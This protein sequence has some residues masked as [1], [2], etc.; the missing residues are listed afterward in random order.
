MYKMD[1]V[2][3]P[4]TTRYIAVGK[5]VYNDLVSSGYIH[6]RQSNTM[7][8]R[9]TNRLIG[10]GAMG[11]GNLLDG[12]IPNISVVPLKPTK[13]QEIQNK[14]VTFVTRNAN[15]VADWILNLK[16]KN[17][18]RILPTKIAELIELSKR[19]VYRKGIP[20]YW[21][22]NVPNSDEDLITG[23]VDA[24]RTK[25]GEENHSK[26]LKTYYYNNIRSLGDISKCLM[27]TYEK[28]HKAFKVMI[29][30]GYVTEKDTAEGWKPKLFN[31]GQQYYSDTPNVIKNKSEMNTLISEIS[32]EKVISKLTQRFPDTKTRLIGI[33]NIGVKVTRLDFPI[34]SK[35]KLPDYITKSPHIISLENADNNLCFWS[36]IALAGGARRDRYLS[37][38]RELFTEFYKKK[39]TDYYPGFDYVDELES[40]EN[41]NSKYAINIV[42]YFDDGSIEYVKK[43]AYN[44]DRTPIYLNLYLDHFSYITSLEKLS[45]M[46]VCDKCS[47]KFRNNTNLT[48]HLDICE[49]EQKD[50]FVKYPEIY[51]KKRNDIVEPSKWFNVDCDYINTII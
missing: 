28:E 37:K 40:Y 17:I 12:D 26:Y 39:P 18:K 30:F 45:K 31:P 33:Y 43:S 14:I 42:K 4:K 5:K 8:Q 10:G 23:K 38:A 7:I 25:H 11:I 48:R 13:Y 24:A 20:T 44:L 29:S 1:R 32:K 3:N 46:Y 35:I 2:L 16:P 36:C 50:T 51:E 49:L 34:G 27:K 15:T 21:Q 6:D 22:I 41:L 19:V 47:C 9:Q